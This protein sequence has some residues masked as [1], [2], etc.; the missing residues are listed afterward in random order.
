MNAQLP[1]LQMMPPVSQTCMHTY[2]KGMD[3]NKAKDTYLTAVVCRRVAD[4]GHSEGKSE[5]RAPGKSR[6]KT[7]AQHV[8]KQRLF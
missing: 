6:D 5:V 4:Q 1:Q 2:Q 7:K 8:A 3:A